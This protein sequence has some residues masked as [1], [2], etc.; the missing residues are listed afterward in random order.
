[1]VG[2]KK[3]QLPYLLEQTLGCL[4]GRCPEVDQFCAML[5]CCLVLLSVLVKFGQKEPRVDHVLLFQFIAVTLQHFVVVFRGLDDV[6]MS[7]TI[8]S[9]L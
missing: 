7:R 5:G 9:E 8:G 3:L 4:F 2:L 6:I 1:M